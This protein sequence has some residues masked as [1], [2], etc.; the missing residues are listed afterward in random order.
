MGTKHYPV[1]MFSDGMDDF[2]MDEKTLKTTQGVAGLQ[3]RN[4]N[5]VEN[6]QLLLKNRHLSVRMLADGVNIGEDTVR[7]VVVEDLRKWKICSRFVPHSLTSE[8]KDR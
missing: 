6:S 3:S 8:Q 7:K 2:A 5:D 1:R 4:D